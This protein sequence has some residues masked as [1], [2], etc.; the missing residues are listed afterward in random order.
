MSSDKILS[1]LEES[2]DELEKKFDRLELAI[3]G[4]YL[5]LGLTIPATIIL[6]GFFN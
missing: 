6:G 5:L 1:G 3:Y 4:I 2:F